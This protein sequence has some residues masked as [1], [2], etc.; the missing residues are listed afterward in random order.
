M[1]LLAVV[2]EAETAHACLDAALAAASSAGQHVA[3]EALHV[4]VDPR[5]IIRAPEEIAI[6][7]LRE[8]WEGTA[9][10]R[11]AAAR[12]A[13]VS[14]SAAN[15]SAATAISWKELVGAEEE[16]VAHEATQFDVLVMARPHNL[17][18]HDALHAALYGSS[19]PLL[20]IP[21][22]WQA[23]PKP[24]PQRITIAWND[25]APA[26]RALDG[27]MPWILAAARVT[28]LLIAE[29]ANMAGALVDRLTDEGVDAEVK[30]I[31][32][33]ARALGDQI[34]DAAHAVD[35]DLLVM[36]AYRH[37]EFV[38]WLFGGTTR[39]ALRHADLPLL[40]AH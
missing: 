21:S 13:F 17:D 14:W 16:T 15:P 18:G 19:R 27:A 2:A 1:R 24:F 26:G 10:D 37:N 7:G 20:L 23:P 5:R 36:G 4:M 38:E 40:M 29:P 8:R 33:S 39:H 6:Q 35:T 11:A 30:E 25:T 9:R 34:I 32:R 31:E 3:I 12:A 22:N 28:I